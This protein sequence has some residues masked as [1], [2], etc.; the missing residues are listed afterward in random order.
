M[1]ICFFHSERALTSACSR[2]L[3][4]I[5]KSSMDSA[6]LERHALKS[7]KDGILYLGPLVSRFLR[8]LS[9]MI[10]KLPVIM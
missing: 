6:I 5:Q 3:H 9:L 10:S 1:A 4:L 7:I 8:R 2:R